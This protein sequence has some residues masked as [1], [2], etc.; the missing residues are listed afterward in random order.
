MHDRLA[1]P[2][3][4]KQDKSELA[5]DQKKLAEIDIELEQAYERWA[6]LDA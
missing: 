5:N 2:D 3:Y 1:E 4:F 6:V